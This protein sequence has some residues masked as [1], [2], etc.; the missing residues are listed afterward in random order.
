MRLWHHP[1]EQA[2]TET[3]AERS[4]R[5]RQEY[6]ADWAEARE[7]VP[8]QPECSHLWES[9]SANYLHAEGGQRVE[10]R[11]CIVCARVEGRV[12]GR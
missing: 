4:E 5:W 10:S 1:T 12:E 8:G 6:T 7:Y 11:I 3:Y 2:A 9:P